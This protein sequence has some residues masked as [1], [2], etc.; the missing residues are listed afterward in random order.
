MRFRYLIERTTDDEL[1]GDPRYVVSEATAS[2]PSY[3]VGT[4]S[5]TLDE[6]KA[7]AQQSAASFDPEAVLVWKPAPVAWQ[8]DA[9]A[10][11]QYVDDGVEERKDT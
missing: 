9:V 11:S 7:L 10:V 1:T 5:L 6:A 2:D 3:R 4:G 8:P